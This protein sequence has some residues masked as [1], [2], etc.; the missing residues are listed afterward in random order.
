[1][2]GYK[3]RIYPSKKVEQTL[4]RQ[5]E[6]CGWLYNRLL[7]EINLMREKGM[8]VGW[9]DTQALIVHLKRG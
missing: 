1:M 3:F 9:K 8:K 4:S 6:L 7:S 2:L 5:L